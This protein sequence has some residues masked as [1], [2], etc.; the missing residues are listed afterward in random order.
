MRWHRRFA[1]LNIPALQ[2]LAKSSALTSLDVAKSGSSGEFCNDCAAAKAHR[3]SYPVSE[4]RA[5]GKLNLV[6]SDLLD[7]SVRSKSGAR[8]L[9]TF[10]DDFSR[11]LWVYPLH[12]K[13]DDYGKI[14]KFRHTV[15][16]ESGRSIRVFRSDNGTEFVNA[17]VKAL[18]ATTCT[19][20]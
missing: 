18:F 19:E 6:H 5:S 17:R 4:S 12:S 3:A 1:H 20:H 15:E 13:A 16:T 7:F 11:K 2:K 14:A 9:I 10:V 8:Y